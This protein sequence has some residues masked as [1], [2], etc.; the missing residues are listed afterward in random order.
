MRFARLYFETAYAVQLPSSKGEGA[1]YLAVT[2]E[3]TPL[4]PRAQLYY[5]LGNA[6]DAA[7]SAGGRAVRLT[8]TPE[9]VS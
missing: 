1:W 2:G 9:V 8:M 4:G 6:I 7:R 5:T 3:R